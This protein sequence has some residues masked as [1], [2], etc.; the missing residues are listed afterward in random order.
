MSLVTH[1]HV[2]TVSTSDIIDLHRGKPSSKWSLVRGK[3]S[4]VSD[5]QIYHS[6]TLNCYVFL[7][8]CHSNYLDVVACR[9]EIG[10]YYKIYARERALVDLT[11]EFDDSC[12]GLYTKLHNLAPESQCSLNFGAL[13]EEKLII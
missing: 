13:S 2:K 4:P 6:A 12:V 3:A 11:A 1:E 9:G 8:H 5:Q 7:P 10:N